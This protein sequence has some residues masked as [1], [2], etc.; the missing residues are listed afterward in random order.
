MALRGRNLITLVSL[1]SAVWVLLYDVLTSGLIS[2][3][4]LDGVEVL[5]SVD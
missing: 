5:C 2:G 3:H 4:L 1:T